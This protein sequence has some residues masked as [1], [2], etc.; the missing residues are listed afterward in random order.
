MRDLIVA[1]HQLYVAAGR[2]SGR[3]I[4]RTAFKTPGVER[5]SHETAIGFLRGRSVPAGF[6]RLKAV[7]VVLNDLSTPRGDPEAVITRFN[8]LWAAAIEAGTAPVAETTVVKSTPEPV[9]T[10]T[11]DEP[12]VDRL[13]GT[14]PPSNPLFTGREALL[15]AVHQHHLEHPGTPLVLFGPSGAGKTQLAREYARR[16]GDAYLESW[17]VAGG[18]Y[19]AA[20]ASM[21]A[22]AERLGPARPDDEQTIDAALSRLDSY[23]VIFDGVEGTAIR[24]L[25][26]RIGGHVIVTTRDPAWANDGSYHHI[27][28]PDFDLTEAVRYLR[29]RDARLTPAA[30]TD[31][32][33]AVG[34]LP[35][36]VEQ[37]VAVRLEEDTEDDLL[38]RFDG[39]DPWPAT[40]PMHYP[41]T[42]EAL[43]RSTMDRL[44]TTHPDAA[45]VLELFAWFGPAPVPVPLLR[46]GRSDDLPSGLAAILG[47]PIHLRRTVATIVATGLVRLFTEGERMEMQPLV[48]LA[49]RAT[50]SPQAS[51]RAMRGVHAILADA[52]PGPP[53]T[54]AILE[55]HR[56]MAPH[57]LPAGLVG[58]DLPRAQQAVY[59]QIRYHYLDNRFA[60]A[61]DLGEAAV[62]AWQQP[63]LLGPDHHLVMLA[64]R[65]LANALRA[66]GRYEQ[67][68]NLAETTYTQLR[69]DPRYGPG[70]VDTLAMAASYAADLRIAGAYPEALSR[71]EDTHARL[72]QFH[73]ANAERTARYHQNVAIDLR[74]LGR[75]DE[76]AA[77]DEAELAVHRTR[78]DAHRVTLQ[79][80]HALAADLYGLGQYEQ[81]LALQRPALDLARRTL[82]ETDGVVLAA[83]RMVAVLQRRLGNARAAVE[84]L[85][86]A[87]EACVTVFGAK[88]EHP[89]ATAM[90]LANAL[91]E[92]GQTGQAYPQALETVPLY[93]KVLG[94]RNPLTLAAEVNFAAILRGQGKLQAAW[95]ANDVALQ[96]LR[97][98]VGERHPF[99]VVAMINLATDLALNGDTAGAH[100]MSEQAYAVALEVCGPRHPDALAA[101]ANLA[102]DRAA[103]GQR[104]VSDLRDQT[105]V[106]L[107]WA[108]GP[109]HPMVRRVAQGERVVCDI[110]PPST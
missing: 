21:V 109:K 10:P 78:G 66:L 94:A 12:V 6:G 14:A 28:V 75:F 16:F 36:A 80:V 60:H 82:D 31:L 70:H 45:T 105:L 108:L 5:V 97:D 17:W 43:V 13:I 64:T 32:A 18:D 51:D 11:P 22:L 100:A 57:L 74:L 25:L 71:D 89:M 24:Q 4:S 7:V 53:D 3:I 68:R 98:A 54:L 65:E 81:A 44:A 87:Y 104:E 110:E 85:L 58:S 102:L 63:D 59:D 61:R 9:K 41:Q 84:L 15:E 49:L 20:R 56:A 95:H 96:R 26:P 106:G 42:V 83:T 67:S 86:P 90:S 52:N 103:A 2:P 35:L 29:D 69:S 99:T 19:Q 33:R 92:R 30:A 40:T 46:Q 91:R 39:P 72:T 48:R 93:Q 1:L 37:A 34:P 73:G 50:L 38:A 77:I 76:A 47:N 23:L 27:G 62:A 79:S 88:H 55:M 107:R 101:A 8:A